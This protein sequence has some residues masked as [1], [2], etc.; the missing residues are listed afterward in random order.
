MGQGRELVID[1]G[2]DSGTTVRSTLA[3]TGF[4]QWDN[5]LLVELILCDIH[6]P[7]VYPTV[8]RVETPSRCRQQFPQHSSNWNAWHAVRPKLDQEPQACTD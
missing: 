2:A 7:T 8:N 5:P 4:G 3:G 1:D 6:I